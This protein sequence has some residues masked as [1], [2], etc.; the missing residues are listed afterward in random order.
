M[1]YKEFMNKYGNVEVVFK[2]YYKYVFT[3]ENK[4]K[5][6]QISCGG[7]SSEIYRFQVTNEPVKIERLGLEAEILG[8]TVN[9]EYYSWRY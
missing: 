9:G 6:I 8:A 3:F 7:D 1:T 2:Q 5:D 4:E